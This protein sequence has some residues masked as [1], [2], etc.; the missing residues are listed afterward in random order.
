MAAGNKR[1]QSGIDPAAAEIDIDAELDRLAA[2]TI[3]ELRALWRMQYGCEPPAAFS[4]D[5]MARALG[6]SLQEKAFGGPE[7]RLQHMLDQDARSGAEKDRLVKIGSIIVREYEGVVHEVM[8]VP[9]GFCWQ[10][11]IYSSL[12][13]IAKSITGTSWNG[14]R[15]FG[16][17]GKY[18]SIP[19]DETDRQLSQSALP[20]TTDSSIRRVRI[21]GA[22]RRRNGSGDVPAP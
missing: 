4:K 22:K 7:P 21:G 1:K 5:L 18:R 2:A 10:E 14:P 17:R 11:K 9:G 19:S 12:S 6:Y 20:S 8:V 16:L 13:T 15:F 3:D